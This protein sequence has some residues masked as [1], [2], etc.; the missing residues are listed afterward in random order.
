MNLKKKKMKNKIINKCLILSCRHINFNINSKEGLKYMKFSK[1]I[2]SFDVDILQNVVNCLI[3][4]TF[5]FL[6][7]NLGNFMFE[8]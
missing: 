8:E 7:I 3:D 1:H 6:F 5:I 4:K 2:L